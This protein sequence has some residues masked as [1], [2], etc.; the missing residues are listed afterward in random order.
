VARSVSLTLRRANAE[1]ADFSFR[2][3]KETMRDYAVATWGTWWE[4]E[5]RRETVEQVTAGRTQIIELDGRPI[6]VQLVE[7]AGTHIQLVQLYRERISAAGV[8]HGVAQ[9]PSCGSWGI[10]PADSLAGTG[11]QS[12]EAALREAGVRRG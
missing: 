12:R 7:Q 10:E 8:R 11:G 2:V 4:E 9:A 1:D 3:L 6:G 5:S